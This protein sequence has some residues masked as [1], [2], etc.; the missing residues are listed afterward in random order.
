MYPMR[1]RQLPPVFCLRA[2]QL[3]HPQLP[4]LLLGLNLFD[5]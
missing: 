2:L 1:V 5:L 3:S 4:R